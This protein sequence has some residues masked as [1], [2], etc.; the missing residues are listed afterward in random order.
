[1]FVKSKPGFLFS[2]SDISLPPLVGLA[3]MVFLD[4][5]SGGSS[6]NLPPQFPSYWLAP[7]P[8]GDWPL[9]MVLP[10]E[11]KLCLLVDEAKLI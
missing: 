2:P 5:L 1:M 6:L 3:S 8:P 11:N 4:S 7:K 10:G 9:V